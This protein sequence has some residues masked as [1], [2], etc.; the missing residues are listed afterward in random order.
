VVYSEVLKGAEY[1][2][3]ADQ[4]QLPVGRNP[5]DRKPVF[6]GLGTGTFRENDLIRANL[7]SPE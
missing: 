5:P 2:S 7:Q 4:L 3:I 1:M 6:L